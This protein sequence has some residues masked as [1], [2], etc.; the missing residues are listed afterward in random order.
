MIVQFK[1]AAN[2][3]ALVYSLYPFF[4]D[5][6]NKIKDDEIQKLDLCLV[7]LFDHNIKT[8]IG[9]IIKIIGLKFNLYQSFLVF[10]INLNQVP[11]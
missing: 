10:D 5:P 9:P 4:S 1:P 8:T 6:S 7:F 11:K 2:T 3:H